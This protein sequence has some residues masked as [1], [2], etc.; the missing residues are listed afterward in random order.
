MKNLTRLCHTL[1]NGLQRGGLI[2]WVE[3]IE[4]RAAGQLG[5]GI[6]K[7]FSTKMIHR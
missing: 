1:L 4:H 6:A 2:R 5:D 7:M 3:E